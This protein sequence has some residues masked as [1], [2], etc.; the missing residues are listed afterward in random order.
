[1]N[2]Q[3]F[4]KALM[5]EL[6]YDEEYARKVSD[7]LEDNFFIGRKN[8]EKT[9]KDLMDKLNISYEEADKIFNKCR[10]IITHEIKEKLK[11]PFKSQD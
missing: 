3:G 8:S 4:I 5:E 10:D 6:N 9:T 11:H 1:M 7:I 2:K